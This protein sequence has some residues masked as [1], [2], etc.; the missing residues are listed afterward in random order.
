MLLEIPEL[1]AKLFTWNRIDRI[2][3]TEHS[4]LGNTPWRQLYD[5]ACDVGIAVRNAHTGALTHWYLHEEK[6]D[7]E[8][9]LTV[10]VFRPTIETLWRL[11]YMNGW[12]IHVLND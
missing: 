11:R 12:E 8:G 6:R 4:D 2:A 9:D 7:A 3:V 5:D 1:D 10:I